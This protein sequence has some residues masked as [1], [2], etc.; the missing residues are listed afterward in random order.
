[1]KKKVIPLKFQIDMEDWIME[2]IE[3]L[4]KVNLQALLN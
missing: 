3:A 1:M 4:G 2:R